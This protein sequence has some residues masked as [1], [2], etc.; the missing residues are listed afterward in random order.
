LVRIAPIFFHELIVTLRHTIPLGL[1]FLVN[2][3]VFDCLLEGRCL[4]HGLVSDVSKLQEQTFKEIPGI[5]IL[6]V[7]ISCWC[8]TTADKKSLP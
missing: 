7:D 1:N 2:E 3:D 6:S 4:G 8:C 5:Q